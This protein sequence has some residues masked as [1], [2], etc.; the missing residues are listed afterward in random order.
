MGLSSF[1]PRIPINLPSMSN[2]AKGVIIFFAV[3]ILIFFTIP[4]YGIFGLGGTTYTITMDKEKG[5]DKK[6][7]VKFIKGLIQTAT[8][9]IDKKDGDEFFGNIDEGIKKAAKYALYSNLI[10][11]FIIALIVTLIWGLVKKQ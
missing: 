4:G 9:K 6:P 2:G 7:Y 5:D 8:A 10:Y 3:W 11:S 1:K